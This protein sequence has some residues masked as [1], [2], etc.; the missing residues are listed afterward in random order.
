[1]A[2]HLQSATSSD[3]G[4]STRQ[5]N[6]GPNVHPNLNDIGKIID[7]KMS[8]EAVAAAVKA[9]SVGEKYHLLKDHFVPPTH[10]K[11]PSRFLHQCQRCFQ[12]RYLR[13]FP[14]M[15]YSP[16]LDVAF[17]KHCALMMPFEGRKN[18]GA[19][20]NKPFTTFHKLYERAKD[21]QGTNYHNESMIAT[22]C[23]LNSVDKPEQNIDNRLD[24]ERKRNI[25]RNRHIIKCVAEA[26]LYCGRQCIALRG[27]KE[28]LSTDGNKSG[29]VGNF[30]AALQMI[31]NH[32]EILKQH[33]YSIGL[34]TRNVKYTSPS[35]QNQV[36]EIIGQDII[37]SKLVKEI[38][39][40][41]FYSIMA[42]EVTS[43][44][45]EELALCARFVDD[46]N[47]VRE[48]FLA[49]LHLPRITGKVI[50]DKITTT[51]HD[52]GLEIA[53]IRGQ[54]YDGAANMSSDNVG[55]QRRIREQSPNAV[56]VHCSGHCLNLVISHSCALPNIRNA[57]D[58]LKQCSLYFLG[59]PKREG[60]P[61][62]F[63]GYVIYF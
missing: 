49:F 23:F 5:H 10:Y 8:F 35:I 12:S 16:S 20:V 22:Q 14:W 17:C 45:K 42:D 43:H 29:N 60:K 44:N 11:F 36:I 40:A 33:L 53:N 25:Q 57:I 47:E 46:S 63:Y 56:Y 34:S 51:L 62:Y 55:V 9:L 21:H 2:P 7:D 61:S 13:D 50:A 39:A 54:G 38:K 27:D 19:F 15:V 37:L 3:A 1:M 28:D 48:E 52:M 24:D 26:V 6:T 31:A 59:S 41:K 4:S 30:L 32:D 18:K 58:K